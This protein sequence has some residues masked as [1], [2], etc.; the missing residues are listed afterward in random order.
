MFGVCSD[1]A[2]SLFMD[3]LSSILEPVKLR[4]PELGSW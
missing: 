2:V 1:E 3:T 4:T